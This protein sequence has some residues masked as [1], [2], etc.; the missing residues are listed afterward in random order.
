MNS[1]PPPSLHICH[2]F[3][4]VRKNDFDSTPS[5]LFA[6]CHSFYR[7]FLELVP[8]LKNDN[9][10]IRERGFSWQV[11]CLKEFFAKK[12]KKKK[13]ICPKKVGSTNF[14]LLKKFTPKN[15]LAQKFAKRKFLPKLFPPHK[16]FC[17]KNLSQNK[18]F[19]EKSST[20]KEIVK[21]K[22]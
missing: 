19:A 11:I 16:N 4:W 12:L 22:F 1:W 20:K 8:Y 2:S 9:A 21:K 6:R 10:S 7:F 5:L 13:E 15:L 14:Y 17:K 18:I 3:L